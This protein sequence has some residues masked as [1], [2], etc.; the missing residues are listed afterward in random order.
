MQRLPGFAF[1]AGIAAVAWWL[2]QWPP[3]AIAFGLGLGL[4]IANLRP[5]PGGLQSGIQATAKRS[6]WWAIVLL[7]AQ[8]PIRT[9][10][11]S[12]SQVLTLAATSILIAIATAILLGRALGVSRA[13]ALLLG[14]GTGICG[15]SAIAACRSIADADD[16]ETSFSVAAVTI[17]GTLGLVLLPLIQLTLEPLSNVGF[18]AWAGASLHAVPQAVAAGFA[19]GGADGGAMS[20]LVKL[21]RVALL[22]VVVLLASLLIKQEGRSKVPT[23]VIGFLVVLLFAQGPI[24][25]SILTRVAQ[26]DAA[27]FLLAFV[28]LGLQT[29]VSRL[30]DYRGV[31]LASGT[32]LAVLV[33]SFWI[34]RAAF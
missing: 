7:A 20:G 18:G 11:E 2:G 29:R 6:L 15:A 3:G 34:A 4:V 19:G 12:G 26:L 10:Q 13:K 21:T 28:G 23:E 22:P 5:L 31:L 32:W 30:A 9:L 33:A 1:V 14:I 24:P 17:L 8:I 25:E 16:D 27:L